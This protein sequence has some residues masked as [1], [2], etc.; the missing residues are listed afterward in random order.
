MMKRFFFTLASAIFATA[1]MAQQ[2]V[3]YSVSGTCPDGVK[4][5]YVMNLNGGGRPTV[6]D[7]AEV[8][9]GK[10]A[11]KGSADKDA[12]L[13]LTISRQDYR[14][15]FNDG[16][17]VKA[18]LATNALTGSELNTKLN[19]YDREIDALSN[20]MMQIYGRYQTAVASGMTQDQLEKL[21]AELMPQLEA[22]NN[23]IVARCK[24]I[25]MENKDNLIPV[26]FINNVVDD[27]EYPELKKILDGGQAWT[28]HPA[29]EGF[30]QYV[31]MLA[32]K[33]A[34]IGKKFIDITENDVD[35]K[36]HK[37]S[38]YCGKGNYV[39]IDFWAS[40]CGP[41]RAEMPNV[42]AAYEKYKGKGFNIVGLSF[43]SKLESWKKAIDDMQ[44]PWVHLSDLKGW[45][46]LAGQTY[47]IRSIPASFLV[48]PDGIIVA[49]DL[50]GEKLGAKLKEI[51]G[52]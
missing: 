35:G 27:T 9:A 18:D 41:C 4:K 45:Q 1:M 8:A 25:I 6:I 47:G 26:V 52:E 3:K 28:N 37:L 34:V 42:K 22:Q 21:Q 33:A 14:S 5:V 36:P 19:A 23:K 20:E 49:A 16:T 29:L 39:L 24:E 50:R 17:P 40:W 30:R 44:I 7:S 43:D 51:Y 38:E 32:Q 31:A 48:N 15:F 10:F 13:G 12:L 11:M 2:Q 46:T